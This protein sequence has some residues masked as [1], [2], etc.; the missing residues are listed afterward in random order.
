[1]TKMVGSFSS[2]CSVGSGVSPHFQWA[3][4]RR[5]GF[6]GAPHWVVGVDELEAALELGD[7]AFEGVDLAADAKGG[8]LGGVE[9]RTGAEHDLAFDE[10]GDDGDGQGGGVD[11]GELPVEGE[12]VGEAFDLPLGGGD[13]VDDVEGDLIAGLVDFDEIGSEGGEGRGSSLQRTAGWVGQ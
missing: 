1:M 11:H 10:F 12:A 8:G 4:R 7:A 3:G 5:A 2:L 13:L 9:G 6:A